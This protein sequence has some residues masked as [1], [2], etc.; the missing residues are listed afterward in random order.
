MKRTL[1]V[2]LSLFVTVSIHAQ[3]PGSSTQNDTWGKA[4]SAPDDRYTNPKSKLYAGPDGWYNYGEVRAEVANTAKTAYRFKGGFN[5]IM[6]TFTAVEPGQNRVM[7]L[8]FGTD[9]PAVG[10]YQVSGKASPAQKKVELSFSDIL[11]SEIRD[12]KGADG[13]GTVSVSKVN[14]FLYIKCRNVL[15]QP[16]GGIKQADETKKAMTL[17]FEGAIAPD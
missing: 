16:T 1:Y 17:G 6:H 10:T 9:T 11:K 7:T 5:L 3:Q 4:A 13:A 12:W 8:D 14:G 15:L 2:A